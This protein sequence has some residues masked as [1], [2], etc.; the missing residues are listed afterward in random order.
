MRLADFVMDFLAGKKV[1]EVFMLPGG[2]TMHLDD[3][4]GR[5]PALSYTVFMHEQAL[6]IAAEA[7]GQHTNFPG[8]GL[9]TSGP[10]GTNTL[11]AVAAAYI[12]STPCFFLSGQ[13]KR[14]DL[15]YKYGVR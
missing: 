15:K 8:V 4:L 12:D 13:T 14:S 5:H 10:G 3:A 6:A 1:K 2:G 9:V 7:Y 11:T